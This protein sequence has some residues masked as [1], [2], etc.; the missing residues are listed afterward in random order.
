[1]S[2]NKEPLSD[3]SDVVVEL[4]PIFGIEPEKYLPVIFIALIFIVLFAIFVLP[5]I[6]SHGTQFTFITIPDKAIIS[7]DGKY[8]GAT[9]CTTF[10]K[11]GKRRIEI[12]KPFYQNIIVEDKVEGGIFAS[13]FVP[14]KKKNVYNM[15]LEDIDEL[16][17]WSIHDF[18]EYGI[19]DEFTANYQIPPILSDAVSAVYAA[20]DN[21]V[22]EK[23]RG[24]LQ[25]AMY[26]IDSE[27]ELRELCNSFSILETGGKILNQNNI[28]GMFLKVIQLKEKY[29]YF[30]SWLIKTLPKTV[31]RTSE[32]K[33]K[34]KSAY[35][36]IISSKWYQ[37][38][39]S[40]IKNNLKNEPKIKIERLY[41]KSE[42][43][44]DKIRFINIPGGKYIM[45][46]TSNINDNIINGLK[47]IPHPVTVKSFYVSQTEITNKSYMNFLGE[48]PDWLPSEIENLL[49]KEIVTDRY[50][51]DWS[52]NTVPAEK[53]SFPVTNVSYY[54]AQAYCNWLTEKIT[55][56]HP[57]LKARLPYEHEWEWIA[58][59][60]EE[61]IPAESY[62]KDE[63]KRMPYAAGITQPDRY[64]VMDIFGSV[65]EWCCDWY[66]PV[67]YL[68]YDDDDKNVSIN[69][70]AGSEKIVRGGSWVN[71]KYD[72]IKSY[73]R[74]S[75]PPIWCTDYLGFRVVLS[76][77]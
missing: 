21:K 1:M 59:M 69:G 56:R 65:W 75:Q 20:E 24:L 40:K 68:L 32:E 10:I 14:L 72:K 54:A 15:K 19:L 25:N 6:L 31:K 9:P 43:L 18:S 46:N 76:E 5:G 45:G 33:S 62:F 63:N 71:T 4:K 2:K 67:K 16:V 26:F 73:T 36:R 12:T 30:P 39:V 3:F 51:K 55:N 22:I 70:S 42:I 44:I 38:Y 60:H 7:I 34:Q 48:N 53:M 47:E 64:G 27:A 13:L 28:I 66:Y 49:N 23:L 50:L 41:G 11:S 37:L 8:I 17:N 29:P 77:L 61:Y 58:K 35:E 57:N 52:G 74:G